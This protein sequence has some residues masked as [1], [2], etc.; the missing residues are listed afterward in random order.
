M[1]SDIW[2]INEGQAEA[3]E[4]RRQMNCENKHAAYLC[5]D[6]TVCP[7]RN[8]SEGM[9]RIVFRLDGGWAGRE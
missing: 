1:C 6:G 5:R 4:Q 9:G 7:L 8:A 3:L 2:Y